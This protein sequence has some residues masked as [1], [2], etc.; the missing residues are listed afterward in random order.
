MGLKMGFLFSLLRIQIR[1]IAYTIQ[2]AVKSIS[3]VKLFKCASAVLMEVSRVVCISW[4]MV[5][6]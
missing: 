4:M 6:L 2:K 3:A 5:E 1:T